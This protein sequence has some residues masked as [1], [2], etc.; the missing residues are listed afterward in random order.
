[1][2][3]FVSAIFYSP[4]LTVFSHPLPSFQGRLKTT[5]KN[6]YY[7]ALITFEGM[8]ACSCGI[9]A[10]S[11]ECLFIPLK[12]NLASDHRTLHWFALLVVSSPQ[13]CFLIE[14][15]T[16]DC[17]AWGVRE[18]NYLSRENEFISQCLVLC[19]FAGSGWSWGKRQE[20]WRRHTLHTCHWC[21][22]TKATIISPLS[23]RL[24]NYRKRNAEFGWL[25]NPW[26]C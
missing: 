9:I 18:I 6:V 21:L 1:M 7:C 25:E 11:L 3:H 20:Q 26:F 19:A 10:K 4:C 15:D 17:D 23:G 24:L 14:G 13:V 5:S 22:F 12:V 2:L 8:V 16:L